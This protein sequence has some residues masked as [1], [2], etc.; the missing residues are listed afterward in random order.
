MPR[1]RPY[2]TVHVN[3]RD[4]Q[5]VLLE[6]LRQRFLAY[7]RRSLAYDVAEDLVQETLLLLTT[8]YA[9]VREPQE[10]M[11]LGIAII[12]KKKLG[13]WRKSLRRGEAEAVD[14]ADADLQHDGPDPEELAERRQ[15]VERFHTAFGALK[16]RCR[17]VVKLKLEERTF[18]EIAEIMQAK[19]NTVYSWDRRCFESLR[20]LVVKGEGRR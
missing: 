9:P 12:R 3:Q 13:Y 5:D 10:R 17:E 6:R 8:K 14:V 4:D 20:A 15:L 18:P 1:R 7:A 2:S 19:L 16:G 11:R